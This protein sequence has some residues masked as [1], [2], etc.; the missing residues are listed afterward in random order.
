MNIFTYLLFFHNG[1]KEEFVQKATY[2][3]ERVLVP[4]LAADIVSETKPL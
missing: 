4:S 3:L 1:S 2:S